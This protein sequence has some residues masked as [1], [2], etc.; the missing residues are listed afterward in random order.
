MS[1]H[2]SGVPLKR[3]TMSMWFNVRKHGTCLMQRIYMHTHTHIHTRANTITPSERINRRSVEISSASEFWILR[4]SQRASTRRYLLDFQGQFAN[5]SRVLPFSVTWQISPSSPLIIARALQQSF[6]EKWT[7]HC[8]RPLRRAPFPSPPPLPA[9][10][11]LSSFLPPLQKLPAQP[12]SLSL[13]ILRS[14]IP[15]FHP[16]FPGFRL[17]R[18]TLHPGSFPYTQGY[19]RRG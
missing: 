4:T 1:L 8:G 5:Y 6:K 14:L 12:L 11:F 7:I 3:E 16:P 13:F 15:S 9:I 19:R 17:S 10:R 18:S 2:R